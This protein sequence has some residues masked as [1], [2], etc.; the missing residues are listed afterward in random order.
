MMT[1]MIATE[2][3]M[4]L[5]DWLKLLVG[6]IGGILS[7]LLATYIYQIILTRRLIP[8]FIISDDIALSYQIDK[9]G[10]K[11]PT[12]RIKI[13]N[14]SKRD[15]YDIRTYLRLR[16]CNKY[17]T[18]ELPYIPAMHGKIIGRDYDEYQR[19]IP[20]RLSYIRET[21]ISGF[22]NE[23]LTA[24]HEAGTLSFE[25]FNHKDNILEIVL[26]ATDSTSGIPTKIMIKTLTSENILKSIKPGK[27][28]K[29]SMSVETFEE[30]VCEC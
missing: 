17:L 3:I 4:M 9:N 28:K 13:S 25:D 27:F 24:K 12:Y 19:E 10:I 20:F 2:I 8:K 14:E 7:G 29:G 30:G 6:F 1:T 26:M 22:Q 23:Q 18:L 15:A 16:Y 21:K 5:S 11:Q